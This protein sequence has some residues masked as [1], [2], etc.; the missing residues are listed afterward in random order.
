M[1]KSSFKNGF[2]NLMQNQENLESRRWESVPQ[3]RTYQA[4]ISKIT[5]HYDALNNW[6]NNKMCIKGY[7]V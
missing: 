3:H 2:E 1:A 5:E 7:K 4:T 6:M